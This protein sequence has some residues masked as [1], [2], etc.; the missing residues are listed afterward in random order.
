M[1]FE[2]D[3]SDDEARMKLTNKEAEATINSALHS[4]KLMARAIKAAQAPQWTISGISFHHSIPIRSIS[5]ELVGHYLRTHESIYR[6]LH[7]PSFRK[8]YAQYWASPQ[9]TSIVSLIKISLVMAIGTCFYQGPDFDAHR[10]QAIQWIHSAQLWLGSPGEKSRL[11]TASIQ[12]ECLLLLARSIY[13]IGAD[14]LWNH[15]GSVLRTAMSMGFH[16]DPRYSKRYSILHNEIR[17]RLWATILEINIQACLDFGM[18]PMISIEEFD[19]EPPSNI[20]DDDIDE[21][22]V[23]RPASHP[24]QV[25]TESSLQIALL[26]SLATRLEIANLVNGYRVESSYEE[27]IRLDKELLRNHKQ[28]QLLFARAANTLLSRSRP[29]LF[30]QKIFDLKVQRFLLV[31]HQSFA[32]KARNDPRFYYSHKIYL[33]TA[34]AVHSVPSNKIVAPEASNDCETQDDYS[35]FRLISGGFLKEILIHSVIIIYQELVAPLEDHFRGFLQD[36]TDTRRER[37]LRLFQDMVDLAYRRIEAGETAVKTHLMYSIALAHIK[38]LESGSPSEEVMTEA[39]ILSLSQ[40]REVLKRR[41]PSMPMT[42]DEP[43]LNELSGTPELGVG[44][45]DMSMQDWGMEFEPSDSWLFS[46]WPLNNIRG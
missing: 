21:S 1:C 33:D 31:L 43:F 30:D 22:T 7:I 19:T 13:N 14:I 15:T 2:I 27:V 40:C 24:S 16:R 46:G 17:R 39:A 9:T 29:T 36:E 4:C 25:F 6:I 5:D 37:Y 20:N 26:S 11:N 34:L 38:A 35:R 41:M 44:D 8:E 32:T 45:M 12:V 42:L 18:S 10:T 28:D 23:T 3:V